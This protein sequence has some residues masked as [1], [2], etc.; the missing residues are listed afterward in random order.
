[1]RE[2]AES[3]SQQIVGAEHP[4]TLETKGFHC[5]PIV[6]VEPLAISETKGFLYQITAGV[7]AAGRKN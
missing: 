4:V 7:E 3:P 6:G 5:L 1:M 2:V